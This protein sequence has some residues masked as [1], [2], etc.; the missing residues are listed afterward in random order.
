MSTPEQ[1]QEAMAEIVAPLRE[2]LAKIER[3][4]QIREDDLVELRK[5]RTKVTRML[6]NV[7]P[8]F[9]AKTK[10][11]PK[12]K[13]PSDYTISEQR[14]QAITDY[15]RA[16]ANG[17]PFTV[18]GLTGAE[19]FELGSKAT[20][21]VALRLLAD[22]GVLRLDRAGGVGVAAQYRLTRASDG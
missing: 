12:S 22:R 21:S 8:G 2:Q 6:A 4:I 18:P 17:Q 16:H 13:L 7:D 1:V 19:D 5:W 3:E 10:P 14:V 9:T 15:L 11:K 20:V